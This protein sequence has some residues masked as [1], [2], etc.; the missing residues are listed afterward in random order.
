MTKIYKAI[1]AMALLSLSTSLLADNYQ[2][3]RALNVETISVEEELARKILPMIR[4]HVNTHGHVAKVKGADYLV[5]AETPHSI[6]KIRAIV[7][8]YTVDNFNEQAF[9]RDL[10][11]LINHSGGGKRVTRII[12]LHNLEAS[13]VNNALRALVG[14][15]NMSVIA[16]TNDLQ[17]TDSPDYV[18][19]MI[20]LIRELD[21]V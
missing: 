18:N 7:S 20:R 4:S 12:K 11:S 8:N 1:I 13:V 14:G 3:Y 21:G 2:V 17:I 5:I 10:S 15:K 16:G 9:K 19:E 6:E